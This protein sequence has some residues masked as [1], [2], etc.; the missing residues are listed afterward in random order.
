MVGFSRLFLNEL[1]TALNDGIAATEAAARVGQP[2][3][4]MLGLG[5]QVFV[6][7][8]MGEW[9]RAAACL[10]PSLRLARRLGARRFEA[11]HLELEGR[12]LGRL[13][14]RD[15]GLRR[16]TEAVA[17]SRAVGMQF[18][19]P[20]AI[21]A[22]ALATEDPSE[23]Q[24]LLDDGEALLRTGA[25]AHNHLWFRRDAIEAMLARGAWQ[26]ALRH[27]AA[28]EDYTRPEP[29]PWSAVFI[30]RARALAAWTTGARD[31]PARA[32]LETVR[33]ALAQAELRPYLPAVVAALAARGH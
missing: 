16:L 33:D 26:Q 25:V 2:R 21:A 24:G 19:A 8:E 4:E 23:Q 22:L 1:R 27:A 13:G 17:L 6:L 10:A 11:Q 3:A 15:E 31:A 7:F 29:L 30:A 5:L 9:D 32:A 12:I 18:T 20:A 14:R 28:L